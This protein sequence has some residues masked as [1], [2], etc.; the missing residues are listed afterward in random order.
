M[1]VRDLGTKSDSLRIET[2]PSFLKAWGVIKFVN[3]DLVSELII[4]ALLEVIIKIIHIQ[5]PL[6]DHNYPLFECRLPSSCIFFPL[7]VGLLPTSKLHFFSSCIA[8][9][10]KTHI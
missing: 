3:G 8:S 7:M 9:I 1:Q 4:V 2:C 10:L 5:I 6:P